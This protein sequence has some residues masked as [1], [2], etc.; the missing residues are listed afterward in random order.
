MGG[1]RVAFP[2]EES[3]LGGDVSFLN[4]APMLGLWYGITCLVLGSVEYSRVRD[5]L[6]SSCRVCGSMDLNKPFNGSLSPSIKGK[7][8]LLSNISK[9]I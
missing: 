1:E 6:I 5:L 3:L 7:A 9:T 2:L 4:G 8:I